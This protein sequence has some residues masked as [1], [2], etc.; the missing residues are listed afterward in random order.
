MANCHWAWG[1]AAPL[2]EFVFVFSSISTGEF[3]LHSLFIW[4]I[5]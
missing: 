4:R 1:A 5:K 3:S 2:C